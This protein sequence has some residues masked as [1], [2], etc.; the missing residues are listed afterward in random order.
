[1]PAAAAAPVQIVLSRDLLGPQ[2]APQVPAAPAPAPPLLPPPPPAALTESPFVD[3]F[4]SKLD[5][6][7]PAGT[8]LYRN[9]SLLSDVLF[10]SLQY[11]Q[12]HEITEAA[13]RSNMPG[14]DWLFMKINAVSDGEEIVS[15]GTANALFGHLEN[16][17]RQLQ[18]A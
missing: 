11:Y 10:T 17:V 7:Y 18:A 16:A 9:Y 13:R 4:L 14:G 2:P 3:E 15:S 12:I 5:A 1:M 6:Q 8:R